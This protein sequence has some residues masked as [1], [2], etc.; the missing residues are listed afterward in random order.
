MDKR[1]QDVLEQVRQ[2]TEDIK[3]PEN[4]EPENIRQMLEECVEARKRE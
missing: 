1:E 3:V 4:L 2:K